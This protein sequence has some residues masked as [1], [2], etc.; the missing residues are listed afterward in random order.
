MKIA[1][2]HHCNYGIECMTDKGYWFETGHGSQEGDFVVT[3][4]KMPNGKINLSI[5]WIEKIKDN[6]DENPT[7]KII[8]CMRNYPKPMTD[9]EYSEYYSNLVEEENDEYI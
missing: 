7:S 9:S 8:V 1:F 5:G 3:E 4:N 6:E 2:V